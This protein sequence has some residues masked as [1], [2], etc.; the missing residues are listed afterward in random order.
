MKCRRAL[1]SIVSLILATGGGCSIRKFAIN[2]LGDALAES[3][4]TYASDD[5]PD[6]VEDALPFGLKLIESLLNQSPRHRG[7]LLAASSGFTQYAYAFIQ[8]NA[9]ETEDRDLGA[10]GS[11]RVRAR[12]LYMRAR[13]YGLRGLDVAHQGLPQALRAN[14]DAALREATIED[15]PLLYWTAVSWGAAIALSKDDPELLADLPEVELLVRR[16]LE[17]DEGFDRGALHEFLIAYEGSR[18]DAMGGSIERARRHFERAMTL[19]EG[20]RAAPL[21]SLAE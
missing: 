11:L 3:G 18:S 7:L 8:Q 4:T 6:L 10:A 20:L 1:G 5:D 9:D 2:K 14:R 13:N 17:L 21:V 16:A 15:V 19:S 12:R